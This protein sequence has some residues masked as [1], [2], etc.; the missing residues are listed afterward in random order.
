MCLSVFVFP[1][2]CPFSAW[3]L[4]TRGGARPPFLAI[5]TTWPPR[6]ARSSATRAAEA[7]ATI[8]CRGRAAWMCVSEVC[9]EGGGEMGGIARL[10]SFS[11]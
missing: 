8:L 11:L 10:L 4:W 2:L 5:I 9:E 7:A 3:S 1:Q 6:S